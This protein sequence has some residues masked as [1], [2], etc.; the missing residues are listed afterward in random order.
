MSGNRYQARGNFDLPNEPN[1]PVPINRTPALAHFGLLPEPEKSP[2]SFIT[3]GLINLIAL[4]LV[5]YIGM[6]AKHVIQQHRYEQ[7][8]LIFPTT[9]PP[10]PVKMKLPPPPKVEPKLP[11]VKLD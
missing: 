11:E 6:T 8:E 5:I 4:T 7:T 3:S 10:P 1:R 2:A 9:P